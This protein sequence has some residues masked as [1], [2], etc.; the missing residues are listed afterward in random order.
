MRARELRTLRSLAYT[1][2]IGFSF[3]ILSAPLLLPIIVF[4]YFASQGHAITASSAFT[5]IALFNLMRHPFAFLPLG[6]TQ[7]VQL[8]V[9]F[10][11]IG[12]FLLLPE[13]KDYVQRADDQ[14]GTSVRVMARA[15]VCGGAHAELA[16]Q[17]QW[18]RWI[19][20]RSSGT[21]RVA[22]PQP[23]LMSP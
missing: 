14:G 8:R 19:R 4:V 9:S 20:P 17:M 1:V 3:L 7:Y 15:R 2:A 11:R 6:L 12:T 16:A 22:P 5:T 18:W 13:L 23:C 10:K 21:R